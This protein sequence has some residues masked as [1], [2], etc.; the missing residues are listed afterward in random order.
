M[1]GHTL[2]DYK[3][4]LNEIIQIIVSTKSEEP[5]PNSD[6]SDEDKE[7]IPKDTNV[8]HVLVNICPFMSL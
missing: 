6:N 4:G 2:F 8:S 3:V 5:L 1:D 7:N